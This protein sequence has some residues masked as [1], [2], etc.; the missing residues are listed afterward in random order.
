[1]NR[2]AKKY[3]QEVKP[4]LQK[5]WNLSSGFAIPQIEKVVIN[6]GITKPED[7]GAREQVI[8]KV[9]DQLEVITGQRPL[10]TRARKDISGFNLR[11]GEPVGLMVTLRGQYMWE[12]L[13]K[14]LSI[15]LPRVRDFQGVPRS[16]FDGH[17]NYS[18]GLEEQIVFAEI[19]YDMVDEVRSLQVTVVTD[20]DEDQ[21]A[22]KLLELL[23]MPFAKEE[24]ED[25]SR[26]SQRNG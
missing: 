8:E 6:M 10:I 17:G 7:A 11:Q 3:Q 16:A 18:L 26:S 19:D 13:D 25:K 20:T 14:L 4:Q 23:G 1:M 9:I 15:T 21:K 24:D 2:L 5:E 12:F 22:F